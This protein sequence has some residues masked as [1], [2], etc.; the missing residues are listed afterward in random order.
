MPQLAGVEADYEVA[1]LLE[2]SYK[3][4]TY[5]GTHAARTGRRLASA[6]LTSKIGAQAGSIPY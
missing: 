4:A 5:R 2:T 1:G 6:R 3:F